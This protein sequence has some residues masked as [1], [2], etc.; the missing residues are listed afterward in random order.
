[1]ILDG[2]R[3]PTHTHDRRLFSLFWSALAIIGSWL[4]VLAVVGIAWFL[5]ATPF[6]ATMVRFAHPAPTSQADPAERPHPPDRLKP[7]P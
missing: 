1:M 2:H 7:A 3:R 5:I 6:L 4:I